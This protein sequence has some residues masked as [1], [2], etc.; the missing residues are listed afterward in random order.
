MNTRRACVIV[1]DS[2][3]IGALPDASIYGDEGSN[4]LGNI[5]KERG[6]LNI[7]NLLSLGLGNIEG[8]GLLPAYAPRAAY[9][10]MAEI[11]AAK[12]TT[13]GHWELAG[14][15]MEKPFVTLRRFPDWFLREWCR[16]VDVDGWL[17]NRAASGTKILEELGSEHVRTGKPIVYTSADSVFQVAAHEDV[18]PLAKLYAICEV[19]REMLTGDLFI[20]RVIA[21]PFTGEEDTYKRTENRRDYAVEPVGETVLDAINSM[22]QSVLGIG[23]IEDIFCRRGV[24][25]V[26]HTTNNPDGIRATIDALKLGQ[27]EFIF[28]NLVD[29]DMLYGHRNDVEGYA[30]ALEY[31]DAQLPEILDALRPD[32][33]L[34]I[35]ADHG[36]DPTTQSTD[37]S[38][39][40]VPVLAYG[41]AVRPVSLGTRATF[42]DLGATVYEQL[43]LNIG[44]GYEESF[45]KKWKA[46]QSFLGEIIL[47]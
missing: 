36:C 42:A 26:D 13:S 31:F 22:G 20:G 18:I 19:A 35:T 10:R 24:T 33:I 15:I 23:T 8:S 45:M 28:T 14:L 5:Y 46:G 29:F 21:R 7:P 11:T 12:D 37:H 9:G 38:R 30:Q 27:D 17:G 2:V 25:R 39:E 41:P 3:G 32:D 40:Y 34:Y 43:R 16:R 47:L 44:V 4:T 1:L 6:K